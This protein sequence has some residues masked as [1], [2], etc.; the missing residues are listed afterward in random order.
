MMK[1]R[2]LT[3]D[4]FRDRSGGW[5]WHVKHS[6]GNVIAQATQGYSRM[7]DCHQGFTRMWGRPVDVTV[8]PKPPGPKIAAAAFTADVS[9]RI[10]AFAPFKKTKSRK[11]RR[12]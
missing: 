1:A 9:N 8:D 5:R 11:K 6:N 2:K 7:A 4:F 12:S 10:T 3:L